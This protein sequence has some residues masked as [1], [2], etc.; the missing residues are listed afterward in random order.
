MKRL[1]LCP[2]P[3][4]DPPVDEDPPLEPIPPKK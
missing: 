4:P 3:D 2:T 1:K